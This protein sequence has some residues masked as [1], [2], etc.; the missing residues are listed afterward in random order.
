MAFGGGLARSAA[1]ATVERGLFWAGPALEDWT[2]SGVA[3][4]AHV[5]PGVLPLVEKHTTAEARPVTSWTTF[6][7]HALT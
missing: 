2:S 5:R 7:R 3:G 4:C 6:P 1:L